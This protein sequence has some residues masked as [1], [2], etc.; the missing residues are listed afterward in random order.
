[1]TILWP[2]LCYIKSMLSIQK[3]AAG[4]PPSSL[5]GVVQKSNCV[6]FRAG[7]HSIFLQFCIP[8][9]LLCSGLG[10]ALQWTICMCALFAKWRLKHLPNAGELRLT[11]SS[12]FVWEGSRGN[13]RGWRWEM[14]A[15][16]GR[17][18]ANSCPC[19]PAYDLP[20]MD[21]GVLQCCQHG[22]GQLE[23]INAACGCMDKQHLKPSQSLAYTS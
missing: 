9:P 23:H 15:C 22:E 6:G 1:M 2:S 5:S 7:K 19:F 11:P 21:F 20:E 18:V 16:C 8:F 14:E 4:A 12:R 3:R 17:V 13:G 10:V